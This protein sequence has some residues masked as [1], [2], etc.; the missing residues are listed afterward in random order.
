MTFE[1]GEKRT[2]GPRRRR[3][4]PAGGPATWCWATGS[5]PPAPRRIT[6][7]VGE[8]A[9]QPWAIAVA[10]N[11]P[12]AGGYTTEH[13]GR[14]GRGVHALQIEINRA[15]YLDEATLAPTAGF[16]RLKADLERLFMVLAASDWPAPLYLRKRGQGCRHLPAFA[17][18]PDGGQCE[19]KGRA[20]R[21]GSS[22][23]RK[24]PGRAE[25]SATPHI[26]NLGCGAQSI[27]RKMSRYRR[28]F[29][30]L[31]HS[32]RKIKRLI[33]MGSR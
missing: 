26:S 13:Y 29:V 22:L 15:L 4:T 27:K 3:W 24:R 17:G 21:R 20:R 7:L 6:R 23:G 19:K 32:L 30:A 14:P 33:R 8:G 28:Q 5:A 25:A 12:Y 31:E 9:G 10:R 2:G 1:V 11:A 16:E 18:T